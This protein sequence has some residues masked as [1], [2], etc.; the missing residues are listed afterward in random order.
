[1]N[2]EE[3][4]SVDSEI[5][6]TALL[7]A[8]VSA[9]PSPSLSIYPIIKLIAIIPL[10]L[11]LFRRMT[12]VSGESIDTPAIRL[13]TYVLLPST[14]ISIFY[15]IIYG[16]TNSR[17]W[18]P[19]PA[20]LA[21][22]TIVVIVA[23]ALS[24]ELLFNSMIREGESVI[25]EMSDKHRGQILGSH[26]STLSRYVSPDRV[27]H[28]EVYVQKTLRDYREAR[29]FEET[30]F[31]EQWIVVKAILITLIGYIIPPSSYVV[32]IYLAASFSGATLIST[33]LLFIATLIVFGVMRLWFSSYGL[34]QVA[35]ES[36]YFIFLG[37]IV[38]YVFLIEMVLL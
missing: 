30:S 24:W 6:L 11:T 22:I 1:M 26:L 23:V 12:V 14:C 35:N 32:L 10:L 21:I 29:P 8:G 9:Y 3:I 28:N 5:A 13:T 33:L 36:G 17:G 20:I 4:S 38:T 19:H 34:I 2:S 16:I 18:D 7:A 15:L 27:Y 31:E 25:S 37:Q